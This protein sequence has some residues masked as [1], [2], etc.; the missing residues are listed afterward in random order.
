M[1]SLSSGE[2]ICK[3]YIATGQRTAFGNVTTPWQ[4]IIP[5][6]AI[7]FMLS[8][9]RALTTKVQQTRLQRVSIFAPLV[10]RLCTGSWNPASQLRDIFIS[11]TP[12]PPTLHLHTHIHPMCMKKYCRE[13]L[14]ILHITFFYHIS[15]KS[16]GI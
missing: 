6:R 10:A 5:L 16:I 12:T 14:E 8:G 3:M 9:C 15:K 1:C 13:K 2:S 7:L 11:T 4:V